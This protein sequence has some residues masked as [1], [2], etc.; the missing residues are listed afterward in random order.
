MNFLAELPSTSHLTM[1][2]PCELTLEQFRSL[3]VPAEQ[4]RAR[5]MIYALEDH[6]K[7]FAADGGEG[8]ITPDTLTPVHRFGQGVYSRSLTM[9]PGAV[10]VGK[11]HAK[12]HFVIMSEGV[13]TV[14]TERG[15]EDLVAPCVFKSP[16]G[17]KRVLM[18]HEQTTWTTIHDTQ[19]TT[20]E[21][22]EADLILTESD[23]I[24]NMSTKQESLT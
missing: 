23:R 2:G 13:C 11:R 17:E 7:Q 3:P 18:I 20:L 22:A 9:P 1:S 21:A 19:T 6:L 12:E 8:V 4:L 15:Q 5:N 14:F 16:A 10:I 24:L